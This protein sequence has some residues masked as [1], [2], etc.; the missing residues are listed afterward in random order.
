MGQFSLGISKWVPIAFVVAWKGG[1]RNLALC[2]FA[3]LSEMCLEYFRTDIQTV[4]NPIQALLDFLIPA[5]AFGFLSRASGRSSL[6][7]ATHILLVYVLKFA[8]HTLSGVL[9]YPP[10]V[11]ESMAPQG[12]PSWLDSTLNS[13]VYNASHVAPEAIAT[14]LIV[15]IAYLIAHSLA[16]EKR[17]DTS[18]S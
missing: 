8:A 9:F 17:T 15:A 5:I 12:T 16:S 2:S 3:G 18:R 7:V 13:V 4:L 14:T 6:T 10:K 1:S 11:G